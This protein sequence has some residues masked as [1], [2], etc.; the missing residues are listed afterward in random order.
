MPPENQDIWSRIISIEKDLIDHQRTMNRM[1]DSSDELLKKIE[2]L[3]DEMRSKNSYVHREFEERIH[4]LEEKVDE[5]RQEMPEMRLTRRIVF[6]LIAFI[7]GI[8]CSFDILSKYLYTLSRN[9]NV[10]SLDNVSFQSNKL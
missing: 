1:E 5:I 3:K 6:A 4:D 2:A 8:S 10:N 9:S 7:I